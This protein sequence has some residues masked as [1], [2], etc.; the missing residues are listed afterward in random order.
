MPVLKDIIKRIVTQDDIGYFLSPNT[1]IHKFG[2]AMRFAIDI[3]DGKT[4]SLTF[5]QLIRF[6]ICHSSPLNALS[7]TDGNNASNSSCVWDCNSRS[8]IIPVGDA[9]RACPS[10]DLTPKFCAKKATSQ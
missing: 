5:N 1:K 8:D 3:Q 7:I 10:S 4:I 9:S 2:K 6:C